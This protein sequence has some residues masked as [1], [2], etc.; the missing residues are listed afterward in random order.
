MIVLRAIWSCLDGDVLTR[1][2]NVVSVRPRGVQG[3]VD[4]GEVEA[5]NIRIIYVDPLIPDRR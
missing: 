2:V 1:V 5:V 3:S 4:R